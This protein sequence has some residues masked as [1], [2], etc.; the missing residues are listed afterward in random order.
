MTR[1][2]CGHIVRPVSTQHQ[3]KLVDDREEKK[4]RADDEAHL[5]HP[6]GND[7]QAVGHVVELPALVGE[8]AGPEGEIADGAGGD[9]ERCDLERVAGARAEAFQEQRDAHE[10]APAESV[11]HGEEGRGGAEPGHQVVAA[12]GAQSQLAHD[13]AAYHHG[14]DRKNKKRREGARGVVEEVE[15]PAHYILRYAS[16][17]AWPSGPAFFSQSCSMVSP[18]FFKSAASWALGLRTAIPLMRN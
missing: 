10:I 6:H 8:A 5:R 17:T 12:A 15:E 9:G 1:L 11:R 13:G 7:D 3:H 18:T 14:E 4:Q 2:G 16:T